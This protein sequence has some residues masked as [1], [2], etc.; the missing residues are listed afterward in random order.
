MGKAFQTIIAAGE[1]CVLYAP[2]FE[3]DSFWAPELFYLDDV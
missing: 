3:L 1:S 2:V